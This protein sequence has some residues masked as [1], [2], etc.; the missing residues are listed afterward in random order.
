MNWLILV[1]SLALSTAVC[2]HAQ[3]M[4]NIEDDPVIGEILI[5]RNGRLV[6]PTNPAF[7]L[8][9]RIAVIGTTAE[10]LSKF[11][12][13]K[14]TCIATAVEH[15]DA[16]GK[17]NMKWLYIE[18]PDKLDIANTDSMPVGLTMFRSKRAT[19]EYKKNSFYAQGDFN[20][21]QFTYRLGGAGA[22]AAWKNGDATVPWHISKVSDE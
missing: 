5:S 8:F 13:T 7:R 12:Y 19:F 20:D 14:S 17:V 15:K 3:D 4:V 10:N 22:F 21:R 9:P 18:R 2:Q 16:D 11:Y 6:I 1:L